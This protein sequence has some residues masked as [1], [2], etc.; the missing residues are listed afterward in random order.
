MLAVFT[1]SDSLE[2]FFLLL[3]PENSTRNLHLISGIKHKSLLCFQ[4]A[5]YIRVAIVTR[6]VFSFPVKD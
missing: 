3:N 6:Y 2:F 4:E 5:G 1:I